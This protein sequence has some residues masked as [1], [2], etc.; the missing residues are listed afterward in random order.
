MLGWVKQVSLSQ[1][2]T[3]LDYT[4]KA[5]LLT[6]QPEHASAFSGLVR[7]GLLAAQTALSNEAAKKK[8]KEAV[9]ARQGL[10]VLRTVV[11]RTEGSTLVLGLSVSQ[12]AVTDFIASQSA[13]KTTPAPKGR[14]ARRRATRRR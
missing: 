7:M 2:M 8:G 6:D 12:K 10:A 1:G 14:R 11:N 3:A 4:L 13:K 5:A 9:Q